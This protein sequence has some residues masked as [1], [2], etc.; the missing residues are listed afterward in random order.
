MPYIP[1]QV[2]TVRQFKPDWRELERD[3]PLQRISDADD[4]Q[5]MDV[6]DDDQ[7]AFFAL[8]DLNTDLFG[9][10]DTV[11]ACDGHQTLDGM[12]HAFWRDPRRRVSVLV[13]TLLALK[14]AL[15]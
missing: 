13:I 14:P 12:V 7:M 8:M 6:N 3:V 15:A 11:Q 1:I 5:A 9:S 4:L 10:R 2:P